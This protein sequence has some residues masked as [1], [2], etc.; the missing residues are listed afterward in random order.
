MS[1]DSWCSHRCYP[2]S[3]L[4]IYILSSTK[5]AM[6]AGATRH[7][8]ERDICRIVHRLSP[9]TT[10]KRQKKRTKNDGVV[11]KVLAYRIAHL[12]AQLRD[13]RAP[14]RRVRAPLHDV[15][16]DS[17]AVERPLKNAHNVIK[18]SPLATVREG[19]YTRRCRSRPISLRTR[20][21][22]AR[23]SRARTR[24]CSILISRTP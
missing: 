8:A 24:L 14:I 3:R 20:R 6:S 12:R 1:Q 21:R 22:P 4:Y 5:H 10:P 18:G 16:W 2:P 19:T 7:T 11:H 9:K 15:L 13:R 23:R 17:R